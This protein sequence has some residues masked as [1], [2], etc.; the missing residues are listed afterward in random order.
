MRQL[1]VERAW[2]SGFEPRDLF[3]H[4]L[5]AREVNRLVAPAFFIANNGYT[6]LQGVPK[7]DKG[8]LHQCD[9]NHRD[10]GGHGGLSQESRIKAKFSEF[11][12][13][14]LRVL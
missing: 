7:I 1:R 14:D 9:L 10:H 5:Q 11:R 4:P 2:Q 6:F 12:V 13:C 3:R 8:V